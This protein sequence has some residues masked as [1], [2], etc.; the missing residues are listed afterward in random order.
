[1]TKK[2]SKSIVELTHEELMEQAFENFKKKKQEYISAKKKY[3]E[4]ARNKK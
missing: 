4:L 1:M 3:Q 2:K